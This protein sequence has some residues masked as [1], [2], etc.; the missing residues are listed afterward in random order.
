MNLTINIDNK[1]VQAIVEQALEQIEYLQD[2][3][4]CF[5]SVISYMLDKCDG[6]YDAMDFLR[7]WNEGDFD[8]LRKE[9]ENVPDEVFWAD[10][11]HERNR[12]HWI[13]VE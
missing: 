5:Q 4:A 13:D 12:K 6:A 7:C 11:L 2:S 9:W 10:P 8:I 1:D 3:E